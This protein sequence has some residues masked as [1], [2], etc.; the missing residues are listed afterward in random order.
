MCLAF[1]VALLMIPTRSPAQTA[2]D[3]QVLAKN[4]AHH[5]FGRDALGWTLIVGASCGVDV[6]IAGVP[7]FASGVNPAFK[8]ESLGMGR[9]GWNGDLALKNQ[10]FRAPR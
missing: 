6:M 9:T 10:I 7:V 1:E 5:V 3:V 8:L 4:M 2:A